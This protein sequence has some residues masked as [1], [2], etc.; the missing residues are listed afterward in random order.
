M[1][2]NFKN[3]LST[4]RNIP[5][6]FDWYWKWQRMKIDYETMRVEWHRMGGFQAS[7]AKLL[8]FTRDY[9]L[10]CVEYA[11][12]TPTPL[13]D[14]IVKA[15]RYVV[16]NHRDI[17]VSLI[18][19]V[20]RGREPQTLELKALAEMASESPTNS[21]YGSPMMILY[22]ITTLYQ[23]LRFLKSLENVPIPPNVEPQPVRRPILDRL[24]NF[25][26]GRQLKPAV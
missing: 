2:T 18:D 16:T 10:L 1:K 20:R 25:L 7:T 19:W 6:Y 9:S 21:E 15:V 13:D 23:V 8:D 5:K 24:R 11:T 12:W 14:Q 17:V 3:I 26:T 22:I 4:L